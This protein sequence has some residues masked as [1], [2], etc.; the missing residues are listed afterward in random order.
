METL[1]QPSVKRLMM[2]NTTIIILPTALKTSSEMSAVG[3]FRHLSLIEKIR[4]FIKSL[5][6][7]I[8]EKRRQAD[9]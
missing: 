1:S 2:S 7:Y 4:E 5:H 3:E 6:D 9:N 8:I